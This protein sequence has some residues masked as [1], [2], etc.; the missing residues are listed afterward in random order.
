MRAVPRATQQLS[1]R[2]TVC[3]IPNDFGLLPSLSTFTRKQAGSRREI[4]ADSGA[5]AR[6][7][8]VTAAK[9]PRYD[10]SKK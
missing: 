1:V 3:A 2:V 4:A 7:R 10:N 5:I 8:P 6:F 9:P